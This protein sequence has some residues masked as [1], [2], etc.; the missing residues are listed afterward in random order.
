MLAGHLE[1]DLGARRH[2]KREVPPTQLARRRPRSIRRCRIRPCPPRR[3]RTRR[4]PPPA[5]PELPYVAWWS[6]SMFVTTATSRR[7]FR[8]ERSDSSASITAHSPSPQA[9]FV[10]AARSSPPIRNA[11]S[12]PVSSRTS[13]I[14]EA[15][16]VFPW[17]PLTAIVFFIRDELAEQVG[18]VE[19]PRARRAGGR[20]LRVVL[21]DGGGDDDLGALRQVRRIVADD[22]L[23]AGRRAAARSTTTP[24]GRTR[25]RSRR[26]ASRPARGR[27]CRHRRCPRSGAR[28]ANGSLRVMAIRR[29]ISRPAGFRARAS[30]S[31][32][33]GLAPRHGSATA[34]APARSTS[35]PSA[36]A[37]RAGRPPR[38]PGSARPAR[39]PG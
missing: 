33:P 36:A 27:S 22:R 10:P 8:K 38:A 31:A 35:R 34:R 12:R 11:G 32:P 1:L 9:A 29:T 28:P 25:S 13:A 23:D 21:R 7:S 4:R 20:Q 6:S 5:R 2:V 24:P 14:I 37:P 19:D 16:V 26:A 17:V 3:R 39:R 15:V 18:A 30:S